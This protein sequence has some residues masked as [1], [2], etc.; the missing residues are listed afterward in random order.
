M[1]NTI[2][3]QVMA[4]IIAAMVEAEEN[5]RDAI[6]AARATFPGT[7]DGVLYEARAEMDLQQ[8]EAWWQS[9]EK[10]IDG[11]VIRRALGA[12]EDGG[13]S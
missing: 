10:T 9:I 7:P 4:Q 11:E 5:G 8:E 12:P 3:E 1:N 2:R 6:N 13:A